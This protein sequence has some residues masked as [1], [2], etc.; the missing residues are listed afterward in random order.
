MSPTISAGAG[1]SA[2]GNIK[3]M[4]DA[5]AKKV[6]AS[7]TLRIILDTD[8]SAQSAL[9]E[10]AFQFEGMAAHEIALFKRISLDLTSSIF[11]EALSS[12]RYLDVA[13]VA[14]FLLRYMPFSRLMALVASS[15]VAP[16]CVLLV[17]AMGATNVSFLNPASSSCRPNSD[18]GPAVLAAADHLFRIRPF[19]Y[20]SA[21]HFIAL[22]NQSRKIEVLGPAS[23]PRPAPPATPN[24]DSPVHISCDQHGNLY[25]CGGYKNVIRVLDADGHFKHDISIK[26]LTAPWPVKFLRATAVDWST[27][28]IYVTDRDADTVCCITPGGQLLASLPAGVCNKPRSLSWC[29]R[30]RRIAVADYENHQIIIFD[31][32][33]NVVLKIKGPTPSDNFASPIDTAFDVNGFLYI[34][35]SR[36]SRW[37]PAFTH[38]HQ[39]HLIFPPNVRVVVMNEA[40][41]YLLSF[42][43]KGRNDGC[44]DNRTHVKVFAWLCLNF[45]TLYFFCSYRYMC[46]WKRKSFCQL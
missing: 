35:D 27:G 24:T 26:N 15:N 1:S 32:E 14:H 38:L 41:S 11:F 39:L 22:L 17:H 3:T 23:A 28:N 2:V 42:G 40:Y 46:R 7:P 4:L 5:A 21:C 37:P 20:S 6:M 31:S 44:F 19:V 34:L 29:A 10:H 9:V 12:K 13:S 33:L 25:V 45:L 18:T 16:V 36:N 30:S 43:T 8:S